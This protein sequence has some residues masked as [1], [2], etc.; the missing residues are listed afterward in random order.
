MMYNGCEVINMGGVRQIETDEEIK[1]V[2]DPYRMK[3]ISTFSRMN[4]PSTVKEIA[5]NMGEVPAKVHYHVKKLLSIDLLELDHTETINGI[6]AKYYKL[7]ADRFEIKYKDEDQVNV[8]NLDS[9]LRVVMTVIDSFKQDFYDMYEIRK[10][11]KVKGESGKAMISQENIY[12]TL[13]ELEDFYQEIEKFMESHR[14]K[15]SEGQRE[16][17]LFTGYVQ[18]D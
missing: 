4:R 15:K 10:K 18:K 2:S 14:E 12:V 17:S 7:T 5:D 13:E 1:I 8:K 6:I 11:N 16:F 3:I 9:R